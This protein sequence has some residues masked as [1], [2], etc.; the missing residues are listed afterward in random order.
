MLALYTP[1]GALARTATAANGRRFWIVRCGRDNHLEPESLQTL[2]QSP[3]RSFRIEPIEKVTAEFAIHAP[4][5]KQVKRNDQQLVRRGH[6][7][8]R[9]PVE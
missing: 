1:L 5:T 9:E 4:I 8:S 6:D 7:R 2:R 3:P